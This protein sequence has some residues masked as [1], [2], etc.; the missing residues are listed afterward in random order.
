MTLYEIDSGILACIDE[1]SGEV[2]DNDKLNALLMERNLKIESVGLWVKNL[3]ATVSAIKAEEDALKKRRESAERKA[4]SLKAWL[5]NALCGQRFET[6]KISLTF[7]K[8]T[9]TEV[10]TSK[11]PKKWCVKKITYTPD[12]TA[13]RK[14]ILAGQKIRGAVLAE[15]QNIQIK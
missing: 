3:T 14:A 10:D 7:R 5:E 9:T 8:S 4:K 15:H 11:L 1:E 13:I 12:K 6:A 2:I